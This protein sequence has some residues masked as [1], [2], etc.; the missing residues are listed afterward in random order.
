MRYEHSGLFLEHTHTHTRHIHV[1]IFLSQGFYSQCIRL[2]NISCPKAD[3]W[4]PLVEQWIRIHL[5]CRGHVFHPWYRKIPHAT[6]QLSPC[7]E[8]VSL[9]T[10][11]LKPQLPSLGAATTKACPPQQEKS[12]QQEACGRNEDQPPPTQLASLCTAMKT[13]NN[14]KQIK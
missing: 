1:C 10:G 4:T 11:A 12:P 13:H 9:C 6:G 3:S 14:Q 7:T 2:F 5:G 8:L